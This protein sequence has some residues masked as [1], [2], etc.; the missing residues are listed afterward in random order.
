MSKRIDLTKLG[1]LLTFQNTLDYMQQAYRE[2]I[3][4]LANYLGTKY[5][6]SGCVD[7]G[8]TCTDGFISYAGEIIPFTGGAL[9][10][11]ISITETIT[12]KPFKDGALKDVLYTKTAA[13]G[14]GGTSFPYSELKRLPLA[15]ESLND[16]TDKISTMIKSIVQFEQEVILEGLLVTDVDTVPGELAISAGLVLFDGKLLAADA[17]A[18]A[19]P[20]YLDETG[21]WGTVAP[22][23]GLYITFNP[24]TSQRYVNVLDRAMTPA[25]RIVM[26]ETLT[27]RFDPAT[28]IGR[29]EMKGYSLMSAMQNRVPVG[30]WFDTVP[31]ADVSNANNEVAGNQEGKRAETLDMT[32]LPNPITLTVPVWN[33]GGNSKVASGGNTFEGNFVLDFANPGGG[34]AHNNMQPSTVVVY[35]KRT[36]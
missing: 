31:V 32:K 27:D 10:A 33:E 25:G 13:F 23:A 16:F 18:G 19:Y 3:G 9:G 36:A 4:A 5:V 35:A 2:P 20:A 8:V 14:V 15:A 21:G 12:Q 29:W 7:N 30:L 26:M 24:Y 1:G 17:Y 11:T 6:V 34:Q 28:F 22:G